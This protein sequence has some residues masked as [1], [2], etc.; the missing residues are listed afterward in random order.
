MLKLSLSNMH[1]LLSQRRVLHY[2]MLN[3]LST[4][5]V[6]NQGQRPVLSIVQMGGL[7]KAGRVGHHVLF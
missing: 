7:L 6:K 2:C 4:I 1:I 5:S 3:R